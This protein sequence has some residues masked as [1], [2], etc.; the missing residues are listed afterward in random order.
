[1]MI[2]TWK[3]VQRFLL[4]LLAFGVVVLVSMHPASATFKELAQ[5]SN[6]KPSI[7][8]VHDTNADATSWQHVIPLLQQD[9]Y[10]VTAVQ[11]PLTSLPHDKSESVLKQLRAKQAM[12]PLSLIQERL[13]T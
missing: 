6:S 4:L 1:M 12:C 7:V 2:F 9:G 11:N 5:A 13:P 3:K 10:T 8:L